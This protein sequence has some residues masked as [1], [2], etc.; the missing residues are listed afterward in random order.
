MN[1][2]LLWLLWVR[3]GD[4]A[5]LI[6]CIWAFWRGGPVEKRGAAII[7]VGWIASFFLTLAGK[8]P[9]MGVV[10]ID[11]AACMLFAVLAIWS[12]RVWAFFATASLLNAVASHFISDLAKLGVYGYATNSGF[13]SGWA[14]LI[15]L[16]FGILGYRRSLRPK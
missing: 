7:L 1:L 15:C 9:V 13:W 14:L 4:I 3:G 5:C 2:H 8:G 11:T 6:V 10:I 16:A 12:R